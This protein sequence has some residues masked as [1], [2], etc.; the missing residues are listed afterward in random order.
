VSGHAVDT[1]QTLWQHPWP[2]QSS[3]RASASQAVPVGDDRVLVSKGYGGGAELFRVASNAGKWSTER[4]WKQSVLKTKLTNVVVHQGHVYGLDDGILSCVELETG[5]R[6]WK[7]G[8]YGHGQMLLAGDVL[9]VLTE[10]GELLMVDPIPERH[11]VLGRLP[12]LDGKT[13]NNLCLY[14]PYLLVRNAEEAACYELPTRQE[15]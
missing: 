13:W 14:G 9:L 4:I 8:R 1:G 3:G 2:G 10:S 7:R 5:R 11:Q 6:R 15:T 12:V